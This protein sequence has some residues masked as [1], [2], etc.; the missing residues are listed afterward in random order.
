[1]GEEGLDANGLLP[2]LQP[3]AQTALLPVHAAAVV[4]CQANHPGFDLA[5]LMAIWLGKV[6]G[7]TFSSIF[8]PGFLVQP[9][10]DG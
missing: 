7:V 4:K 9:Q 3:D 2:I 6:G 10:L 8:P 5:C 1:M